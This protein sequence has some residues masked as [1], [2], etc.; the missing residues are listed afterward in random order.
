MVNWSLFAAI[1]NK[2]ATYFFPHSFTR[3]DYLK[4]VLVCSNKKGY[5]IVI[6]YKNN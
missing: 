1:F 3:Q 2:F 5:K 6:I 4:T